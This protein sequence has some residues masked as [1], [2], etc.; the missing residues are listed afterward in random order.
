MLGLTYQG[1]EKINEM[2]H[3]III[4]NTEYHFIENEKEMNTTIINNKTQK[5]IAKISVDRKGFLAIKVG[6]SRKGYIRWIQIN[7]SLCPEKIILEIERKN[8]SKLW[9]ELPIEER[10]S[11]I[12][13]E[14]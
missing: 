3:R 8:G 11:Q 6:K 14:A 5:V 7:G 4:D 10:D 2:Q 1:V 9:C 12:F 13:W